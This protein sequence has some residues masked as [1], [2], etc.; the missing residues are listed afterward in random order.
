MLL[1]L[2]QVGGGVGR[3]CLLYVRSRELLESFSWFLESTGGVLCGDRGDRAGR[4]TL[5]RTA[6]GGMV[7]CFNG[8]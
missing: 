4:H 6:R 1:L 5:F 3:C 2:L 7:G 8:G